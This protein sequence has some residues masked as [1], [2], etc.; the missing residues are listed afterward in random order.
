LQ[1]AF[2]LEQL[3]K[4]DGM[5]DRRRELAGRFAAYADS[6]N[7]F[8]CFQTPARGQASPF[9]LPMLLKGEAVGSR[10]E[11]LAHLEKSGVETR[12]VVTGNFA[13]QP[14]AG[15]LGKINPADYPGAEWIHEQGFY[16]GLSPMTDDLKLE[17]LIRTLDEAYAA[18]VQPTQIRKAA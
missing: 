12:P 1:A 8:E 14:A 5:N 4:L 11:L 10:S 2:G 16:L 3:K 17:R 7:W 18:V 15:L 9:A 6:Q 13:R